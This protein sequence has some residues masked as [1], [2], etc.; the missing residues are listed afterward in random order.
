[1]EKQITPII[2]LQLAIWKESPV[3]F[4]KDVFK[5]IPSGDQAYFL[6]TLKDL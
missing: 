4:F 6:E 1:M 2:A 5:K 3:Q